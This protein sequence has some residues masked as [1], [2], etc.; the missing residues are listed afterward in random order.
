[1]THA[2]DI[3]K[4][5][6]SGKGVIGAKQVIDGLRTSTIERAFLSANCEKEMR[7]DL[8]HYAKL[9]GVEIVITTILRDEL[10]VL[11]KKPFGISV[12]GIA[13]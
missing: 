5:I 7:E 9:S 8:I 2:D 11:C 12:L 10:G 6:I 13:K 4:A 1:M 3:K